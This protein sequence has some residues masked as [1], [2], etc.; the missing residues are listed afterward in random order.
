M[1]GRARQLVAVPAAVVFFARRVPPCH[2][3][4]SIRCR[5]LVRLGFDGE[6]RRGNESLE[7]AR[8]HFDG[9]GPPTPARHA[10]RP[11]HETAI[12]AGRASCVKNHKR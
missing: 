1:V 3:R 6:G 9:Q 12:P 8:R 11:F 10:A 5:E 4:S 7:E 2:R